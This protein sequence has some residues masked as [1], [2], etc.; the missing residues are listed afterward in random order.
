MREDTA[1]K[2]APAAKSPNCFRDRGEKM[3]CASDGGE[4]PVGSL[5]VPCC[6]K[7]IYFWRFADKGMNWLIT[8]QGEGYFSDVRVVVGS[9]GSQGSSSIRVD[10]PGS[11]IYIVALDM[12][13]KY[14][15]HQLEWLE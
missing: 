3:D 14:I 12:R 9:V 5:I 6:R 4:G 7:A 13:H 10:K 11:N 2:P 8:Q 15:S 1:K